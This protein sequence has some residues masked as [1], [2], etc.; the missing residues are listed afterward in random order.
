[1]QVCLLKKKSGPI[2]KIEVDSKLYILLLFLLDKQTFF[3]RVMF[4]LLTICR[5]ALRWHNWEEH[6]KVNSRVDAYE[7]SNDETMISC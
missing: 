7:I 6:F 4:S 1:M 5:D 3:A 2:E